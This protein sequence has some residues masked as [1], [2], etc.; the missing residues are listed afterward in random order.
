MFLLHEDDYWIRCGRR[1]AWW[2]TGHPV[3]AFAGRCPAEGGPDALREEWAIEIGDFPEEPLYALHVDGACV[4]RFDDWPASWE[5]EDAIQRRGPLPFWAPLVADEEPSADPWPHARLHAPHLRAIALAPDDD[6]PRARYADWLEEEGQPVRAAFLRWELGLPH[7]REH[8]DYVHPVLA[9]QADPRWRARPPAWYRFDPLRYRRGFVERLWLAGHDVRM[10]PLY[11]ASPEIVPRHLRLDGRWIEGRAARA[12]GGEMLA[13]T[14]TLFCHR[15]GLFREAVDALVDSPHLDGLEALVLER[16]QIPGSQLARLESRFGPRLHHLR[17]GEYRVQLDRGGTISSYD[18]RRLVDAIGFADDAASER[19]AMPFPEAR[20]LDSRLRE[21]D[22]G[23]H[24]GARPGRPTVTPIVDEHDRRALARP[25]DGWTF[26]SELTVTEAL[27]ALNAI[28]MSWT[29]H[30]VDDEPSWRKLIISRAVGFGGW[31]VLFCGPP[32]WHLEVTY[33]S[34]VS[35]PAA[36]LEDLEGTVV[37]A[38]L[39]ALDAKEV[40]RT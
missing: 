22:H 25:P 36:R 24:Y 27:A 32:T 17:P 4:G 33:P 19:D 28:H 8:T 35:P 14:R 39:P 3:V 38:V 26:C 31:I 15:A 37:N 21:L 40:R 9:Y 34:S 6:T 5:P 30:V 29:W 2:R 7:D 13:A 1:V 23:V 11:L 16:C 20:V 18:F 12:L 10:L